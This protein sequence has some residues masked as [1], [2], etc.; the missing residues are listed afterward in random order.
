MNLELYSK[1]A[2]KVDLT[3]YGLQKGDVAVIVEK[4]PEVNGKKGVTLEVF[5]A[6]GE[7]IAIPTLLES[8]IEPLNRDEIFHI[9]SLNINRVAESGENFYR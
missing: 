6:L 5:N 4:H 7:T 3:K 2:L 9:R 1:V 8:Q